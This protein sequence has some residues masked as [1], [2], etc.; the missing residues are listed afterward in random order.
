MCTSIAL[1]TP[2]F[3]F[4]RNLDLECGFGEQVVITPRQYPFSF[5]RAGEMHSHYAFIGMAAVM[6]GYPL[7]G[8][9]VN[10]HGLAIAALNFPGNAW[11][12]PKAQAGKENITPFE[13]IPFLLGKCR[14][15]VEAKALLEKIHLIDIPFSDRIPLTPLHWHIADKEGSLTLECTREGMKTYDNPVGVLANNPSFDFHM[16]NLCQYL[17]LTPQPVENQIALQVPLS[18]FSR[19]MG[20]MGLPGDFSSPSRF[21]R[22]VFLKSHSVCDPSM[23]GEISQ[24]FHLLDS[25]A[26][27]RGGVALEDG[28][29]S[30]T[31][32]SCCMR[33]GIYFYKTYDNSRI[34]GVKM[35]DKN[36][37]GSTLISFPLEK[38]QQIAWQ[39]A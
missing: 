3:C 6:D 34:T 10:E 38:S 7:Y 35:Q 33:E 9:A 22:A 36:L 18:S 17:S 13:L 8:D 14:K 11:Y 37:D 28:R 25:V 27:P 20:A 30:I 19:G 5:R 15:L 2:A 23:E 29:Y 21:V 12:D 32:Y 39:Q 16:L 31:Q 1:N 4:G 26:M 24:F